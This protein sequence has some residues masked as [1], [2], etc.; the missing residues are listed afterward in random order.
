MTG[1]GLIRFSNATLLLGLL[2]AGSLQSQQPQRSGAATRKIVPN[3][4][5][6]PITHNVRITGVVAWP[7]QHQGQ[8]T[9]SNPCSQVKAFLTELKSTTPGQLRRR[10]GFAGQQADQEVIAIPWGTNCR[11]TFG[12]YVPEGSPAKKINLQTTYAGS[13]SKPATIVEGHVSGPAGVTLPLEVVYPGPTVRTITVDFQL[14][15]S[16]LK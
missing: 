9:G 15:V 8:P 2:A 7:P 6:V 3:V 14:A 4:Q 10:S 1:R 16:L 5:A 12:L 11:Y 13:W